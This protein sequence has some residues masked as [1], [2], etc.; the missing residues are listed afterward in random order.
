MIDIVDGG[1]R[2]ASA[3]FQHRITVAWRSGG[4][5][6]PLKLERGGRAD[7]AAFVAREG[8]LTVRLS[9]APSADA[10]ESVPYTL[11]FQSPGEP[12]RVQLAIEIPDAPD[13]VEPFHQIPSFLFGDNNIAHVPPGTS[14]SLT[15]LHP[16]TPGCASEWECRAD[17]AAVPVSMA[18]FAG[19]LAGVSIP[20]YSDAKPRAGDHS[21]TDFIRNG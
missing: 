7:G 21:D 4:S 10:T 6:R 11:S 3:P 5:W 12:T 15:R 16:D 14:A 2:F 19:G 17:R 1:L 9:L 8:G 18:L 20:P 13:G